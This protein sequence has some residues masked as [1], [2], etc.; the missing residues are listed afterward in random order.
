M[1]KKERKGT[2]NHR[3]LASEPPRP[4][5]RGS[6]RRFTLL[7]ALKAGRREPRARPCVLG[8]PAVP[9]A[10]SPPRL[11]PPYMGRLPSMVPTAPGMC[12]LPSG[13][14]CVPTSVGLG[15]PGRRP[16][17]PLCRAQKLVCVARAPVPL[18]LPHS[19]LPP[20][21]PSPADGAAGGGRG[22]REFLVLK[23]IC[24]LK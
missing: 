18:D 1:Q 15:G 22:H 16:A 23:G 8:R 10:F 11:P 17:A 12:F 14:D 6:P 4:C 5:R 13:E 21:T 19:P 2:G 7:C 9:P 24:Q 3:G 20:P